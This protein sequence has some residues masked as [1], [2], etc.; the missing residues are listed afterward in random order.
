MIRKVTA[1]PG[2]RRIHLLAVNEI[3]ED[4]DVSGLCV[5]Y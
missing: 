3:P 1:L 2:K 4:V 5:D